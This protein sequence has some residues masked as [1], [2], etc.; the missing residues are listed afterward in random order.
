[1][2]S[3]L[4]GSPLEAQLRRLGFKNIDPAVDEDTNAKKLNA[5]RIAVWHVAR[6]VAPFV[7]KQQGFSPIDFE[8]SAGLEPNDLYLAGSKTFPPALAETWQK[9]MK[10]I[11]EDGSFARIVQK[12]SR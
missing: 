12:Y 9:A 8:Y 10:K 7:F 2:P 1:M 11:K 4:L 5:G 6:M 3:V